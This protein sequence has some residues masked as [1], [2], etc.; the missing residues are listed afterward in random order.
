LLILIVLSK[1]YNLW[2]SSLCNFLQPPVTSSFSIL[3][4]NTLRLC[5][6]LNVRDHVPHP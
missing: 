6:F 3:F 4:S 5:S 2:S 1:E